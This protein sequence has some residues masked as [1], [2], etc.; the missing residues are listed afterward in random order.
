MKKIFLLI[1]SILMTLSS[2]VYAQSPV[3]DS[4]FVSQPILCFG[5]NGGIQINVDQTTP[6]T[7]VCYVVGR[8]QDNTTS[9]D[10]TSFW[11][12]S[13]GTQPTTGTPQT[14]LGLQ[15]NIGIDNINYFVRIVDSALYY[16]THPSGFGP[17]NDG[18]L[19]QSVS[20]SLTQPDQLSSSLVVLDSNICF[21]D[22]IAKQEL[23]IIGGTKP[24]KY[25]FD[26]NPQ[27]ILNLNQS[28]DTLNS[29]CGGTYQI[30]VSD[31]NGCTTAPSVNSVVVNSPTQI[32][33]SIVKNNVFCFGGN[34]WSATI[35][36]TSGGSPTSLVEY[37]YSWNT[38]PP[39]TTA[40]A[41]NLTQGTYL[42]TITDSLGCFTITPPTFISEPLQLASSITST[43]LTCPNS[44]DGNAIVTPSG[45]TPFAGGIFLY[46]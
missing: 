32:T 4:V 35:I 33:S 26:S 40:T 2:S 22:C 30:N 14:I 31:V 15:S 21:G 7:P 6:A 9:P 43:P 11:L 12:P 3:I 29:L 42:C 38:S 24:Y 44:N 34:N 28:I 17:G 41:Q 45:G 27:V 39:Q 23:Q 36:N 25:T 37:T 5:Q 19:S 20:I 10:S 8:Y 46:S 18:V 13:I 16:S 1:S